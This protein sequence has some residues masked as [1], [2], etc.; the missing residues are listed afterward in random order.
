M[1][2]ATG[3]LKRPLKN[4]GGHF[5]LRATSARVGNVRAG[6]PRFDSPSTHPPLT[7]CSPVLRVSA[8]KS[9]G[10]RGEWEVSSV[11]DVVVLT[12]QVRGK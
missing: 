10:G 6:A 2:T 7:S 8:G 5:G 3:G 4:E 11:Q 9:G 1:A 12:C